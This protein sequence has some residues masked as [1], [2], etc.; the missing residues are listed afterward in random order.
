MPGEVTFTAKAQL[1]RHMIERAV[2]A[3]V[4]FSWVTGHEV[5]GITGRCAPGWRSGAL[6]LRSQCHAITGYQLGPPSAPMSS[7]SGCRAGLAA[8]VSR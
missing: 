2:A 8:A 7:P 1:A 5:Y 3:K 4:P 6:A